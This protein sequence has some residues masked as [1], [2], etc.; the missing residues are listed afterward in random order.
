MM[1]VEL[2]SKEQYPIQLVAFSLP[3]ITQREHDNRIECEAFRSP[4]DSLLEGDS[5]RI[6]DMQQQSGNLESVI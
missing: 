4:F 1:K 3:R 2:N 6:V 5:M